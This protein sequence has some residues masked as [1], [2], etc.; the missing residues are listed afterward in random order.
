MQ[1]NQKTLKTHNNRKVLKKN[2]EKK[3]I[4]NSNTNKKHN[5]NNNNTNRKK[6]KYQPEI[7]RWQNR[8]ARVIWDSRN[9]ICQNLK[10]KTKRLLEEKRV[11][12]D[13][14]SPREIKR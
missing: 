9:I 5:K 13:E 2:W 4:Y 14:R 7:M 6:K 11:R 3:H 12:R 10:K 8:Y 1:K